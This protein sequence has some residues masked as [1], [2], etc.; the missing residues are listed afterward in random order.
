MLK[1]KE[2]PKKI[3]K[4]MMVVMMEYVHHHRAIRSEIEDKFYREKNYMKKLIVYSK[5]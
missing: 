1:K 4:R 5:E 2:L 3:L